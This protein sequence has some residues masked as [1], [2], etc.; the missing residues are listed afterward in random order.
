MAANPTYTEGPFGANVVT[1]I[2]QGCVTSPGKEN[3][4]AYCA[5]GG[6]VA[7]AVPA[8]KR[9]GD[10]AAFDTNAL[11]TADQ[12]EFYDAGG[13]LKRVT[14]DEPYKVESDT[15]GDSNVDSVW[16]ISDK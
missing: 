1:P 6:L 8:G 16:E 12:R 11:A 3:N 14:S 10:G 13:A 7:V 4:Q 5:D 2:S 9:T 15:D